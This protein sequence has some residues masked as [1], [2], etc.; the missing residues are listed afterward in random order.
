MIW[1]DERKAYVIERLA[2]KDDLTWI[3]RDFDKLFS[4]DAISG[5]ELM[6]FRA[7]HK[8]II[9]EYSRQ[10]LGNCRKEP[11]AHP[12][13]R[14][15]HLKN[16]LDYAMIPQP[17]K[18]VPARSNGKEVEYEITYA[19]DH[20]AI[21][22]I[23]RTAQNEEFFSKKFFLDAKKLELSKD[24]LGGVDESGFEA[25]VVDTGIKML[26]NNGAK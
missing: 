9:E 1:N 13:I 8:A 23:I 21:N 14:L 17:I 6:R 24:D 10:E 12:R 3:K 2:M 11:L 4:P 26:G 22:N 18:S 5:E 7:S 19:P 15:R 25:I 16:A 20:S